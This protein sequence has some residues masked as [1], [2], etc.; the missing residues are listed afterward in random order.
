MLKGT[1]SIAVCLASLTGCATARSEP[2][3]QPTTVYSQTAQTRTTV[4]YV[5]A[6]QTISQQMFVPGCGQPNGGTGQDADGVEV[7][8]ETPETAQALAASGIS[9]TQNGFTGRNFRLDA[10]DCQGVRTE[11]FIARGSR[12]GSDGWHVRIIAANSD[13]SAD[14]A[15]V[16][17]GM[18]T[19]FLPSA[20]TRACRT[21]VR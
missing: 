21:Q 11:R 10:V 9:A 8:Y 20:T 1:F 2:G 5:P 15:I 17:N 13:C 19:Y 4:Q 14:L 12:M 3:D 18:L 6:P 7:V 16:Q